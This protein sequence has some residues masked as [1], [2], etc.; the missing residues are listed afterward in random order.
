MPILGVI[1]SAN[2]QGRGGGPVSAYD[3]LSSITVGSTNVSSISFDNIPSGY[4]HLQIRYICRST[5]TG[6][7]TGGATYMRLNNDTGN[8][9]SF[10]SLRSSGSSV[11][12]VGQTSSGNNVMYVNG[13]AGSGS[14]N[15]LVYGAAIIDIINYSTSNRSKVIRVLGGEDNNGTT[16]G[17]ID[18]DSGAWYSNAPVT[19]IQ[20]TNGPFTVNSSFALYGVK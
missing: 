4:Q 17:F 19:S 12:S 7:V 10:H 1:A 9:Y 14:G 11:T 18:I 8:N 13:N 2:Q 6:Y 16:A 5:A 15:T 20:I 3:S